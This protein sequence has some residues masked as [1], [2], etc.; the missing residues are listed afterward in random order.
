MA[1]TDEAR[2]TKSPLAA[3]RGIVVTH[4]PLEAKPA[5]NHEA[6]TRAMI[7]ARLAALLRF[8]FGGEYDPLAR[9]AAPLYLVPGETL[10]GIEQAAHVG[11]RSERDLYGGV[12]PHAFIATKA[13]THQLVDGHARVPE[14]WSHVFSQRVRDAILPGFSAFTAED[15]RRG[16]L[17]L[18]RHGTVRIKRTRGIGGRGQ[19]E[20]Q[21]A[22]ELDDAIAT[23][24]ADEMATSG[25]VLEL[26]L[27]DV[28]TYSV[29]QVRV[30]GRVAS[31]WGKQRLTTNNH[32]AEVY[33][34]SELFVVQGGFDALESL[35][36]AGAVSRAIAHARKYDEAADA[37]FAGFFASRRNYDVAQGRDAE[38]RVRSGVLEQ[39][40]RI[41]GASGAE[42]AALEA[43]RADPTA[44]AV[45][46]ATWETYG[47]REPP[48]AGAQ[49]L[50]D[51]VDE[52]VGRLTKYVTI[53]PHEHA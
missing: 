18:L 52:H 40:W 49:I 7:A 15:A 51:G 34:G 24:A 16:G 4:A 23:V 3:A 39:S 21:D 8:E 35:A 17:R 30:G 44:S 41:G 53:E 28:T 13:I 48:P 33:G 42:V 29:G 20:V 2:S 1:Q 25:V 5:R 22:R 45:R 31:Y 32:G 26:H 38:G 10:V 11:A 47:E 14:G 9:Y 12:V 37:C 50:Y 6:V 46:A 36:P 27:N 19:F 43:F